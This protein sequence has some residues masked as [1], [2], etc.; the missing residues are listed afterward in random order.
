MIVR[1]KLSLEEMKRST[2]YEFGVKILLSAHQVAKSLGIFDEVNKLKVLNP[3]PGQSSTNLATK[4]VR[5]M[6]VS[7]NVSLPTVFNVSR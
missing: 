6:E 4:N 7:K 5:Y 2:V 3:G 1:K